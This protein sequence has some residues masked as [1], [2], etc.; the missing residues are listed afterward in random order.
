MMESIAY[1]GLGLYALGLVIAI[2]LLIF[3]IRR[4]IRI[5]KTENFEKRTN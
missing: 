1:I 4:R 2:I 5:R 3:L